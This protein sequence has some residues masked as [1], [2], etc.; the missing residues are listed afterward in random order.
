MPLP[1]PYMTEDK[2][3]FLEKG[4]WKGDLQISFFILKY[5]SKDINI[6]KYFH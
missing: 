2:N 3:I 1:R 5:F 6:L 4:D